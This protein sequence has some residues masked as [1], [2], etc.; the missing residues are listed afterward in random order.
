MNHDFMVR[1][2]NY[3]STHFTCQ[4]KLLYVTSAVAVKYIFLNPNYIFVESSLRNTTKCIK[5]KLFLPK[6]FVIKFQKIFVL[7]IFRDIPG[8]QTAT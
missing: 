2:K 7:K 6:M 5:I 4:N 3:I 1:Y 8:Q